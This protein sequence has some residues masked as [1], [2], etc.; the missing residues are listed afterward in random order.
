ML[1]LR[2]QLRDVTP[3]VWRRILVAGSIRMAKL[4]LILIAAM[5]WNNSHPHE[6]LIGDQRIGMCFDDDP[7]DDIDEKSVTVLQALREERRFSFAYD[8]GDSWDHDV[9]VEDLTWSS[10]ALTFAVCLEG[11]NACPPDDVGGASGYRRFV[12]AITDPEH[13]EHDRTIGWVDGPFDPTEF[14]VAKA[15]ALMQRVR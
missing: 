6:F 13:E 14:D 10:V 3:V 1:S 11:E 2:I 5:G 12:K 7:E 9:V 15:N 8:F 4:S